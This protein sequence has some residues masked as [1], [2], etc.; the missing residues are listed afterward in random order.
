MNIVMFITV[1]R[2]FAYIWT[3]EIKMDLNLLIFY[4]NK[5]FKNCL[6]DLIFLGILMIFFIIQ[7]HVIIRSGILLY[8][9]F[10]VQVIDRFCFTFK[11][12]ALYI[13]TNITARGSYRQGGHNECY[14]QI[15]F[16]SEMCMPRKNKPSRRFTS[17]RLYILPKGSH[18]EW[19]S[20]HK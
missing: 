10:M 3:A 5:V 14:W 20:L 17:R 2:W 18:R 9:F 7:D 8:I 11:I 13:I 16:A 19:G 6:Y 12:H 15:K 1:L 4:R